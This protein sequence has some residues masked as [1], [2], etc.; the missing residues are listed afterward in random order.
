MGN[1][2]VTIHVENFKSLRDFK[3]IFKKFNVL[4]GPNGSGK[5]NVLELFKF[6]SLCINPSGSPAYPFTPW[7]GFG[8]VVWSGNESL[9]IC[10]EINFGIEEYAVRYRM[11]VSGLSG[12]CEF[13]KEELDI[14]GYL[15]IERRLRNAEYKLDQN[16]LKKVELQSPCIPLYYPEK[17]MSGLSSPLTSEPY[18]SSKSILSSHTWHP[19]LFESTFCLTLLNSSTSNK[20][21]VLAIPAPLVKDNGGNKIPIQEYTSNLFNEQNLVLLRQ[22]NYNT[23][24]Q[25]PPANRP[26]VLEEDGN[27]LINILFRWYTR[28][29]GLPERFEQALEELFPHWQ[30]RFTTTDDG[31]ILLNVN[32]GH[33]LLSPPSIPDGFYKLLAILAAIEL[34]PKFLLI[35]E[36]DTSLHARMIEYILDELQTCA[37]NVVITTHSPVVIDAVELDDLVL[38]ERSEGETVCKRIED[39]DEL[40]RQ[41]HSKGITVSDNWIYGKL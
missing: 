6:A 18:P 30:I 29:N 36:M 23:L 24:R 37:A 40:N 41:L 16:F 26:S 20:S 22:P 12:N 3:I 5:T 38:L 7:W 33:M 9:P 10:L 27:G 19:V 4:I 2:Y 8:N 35:D 15:H 14:P 21:R 31:R 28:D 11:E 17:S 25:P 13:L 39:P 1:Q 32:D 34:N